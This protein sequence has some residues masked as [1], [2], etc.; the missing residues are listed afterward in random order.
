MFRLAALL[1]LASAVMFASYS[2]LTRLTARD[3]D[4]FP[5]FFWP[6]IIGAV[7]MTLVG[8]P[9]WEPIAAQDW[10][11]LAFYCALSVLSHWLL[12]KCYE[13]TEAAR[14]QPFAY[15]QIVFVSLIGLLVYDETL[16]LRVIL[17]TGIIVAAGL[18]ALWQDQ[19]RV[20]A[21]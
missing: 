9:F 8:L 20:S 15:L 5:A 11:P 7:L 12:L 17:G 10:L 2:V 1:P 3:E 16:A 4:T 19:R 21:P 13:A 18:F 6:G 14:V